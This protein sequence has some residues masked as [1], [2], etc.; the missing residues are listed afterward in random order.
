MKKSSVILLFLFLLVAFTGTIL[1]GVYLLSF[2]AKSSGGNVVLEW[3]TGE[4][5]N[6]QSIVIERK[7]VNG[8][9][10]AIVSVAPKGSNS[11]Y[12]YT[13][14]TAYKTTDNVYKYRLRFIFSDGESNSGEVVV[15]NRNVSGVKRTWGSIKAMFR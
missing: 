1:A 14:Q 7:T 9:F 8:S 15:T 4:E 11:Y 13:D 10:V 2:T 5:N 3:N 12:T 6:L